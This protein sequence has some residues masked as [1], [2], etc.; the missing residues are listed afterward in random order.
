MNRDTIHDL[1]A[2]SPVLDI[3]GSGP[4]PPAEWEEDDDEHRCMECHL[5]LAVQFDTT[6]A[7]QRVI[8]LECECCHMEYFYWV[9]NGELEAQRL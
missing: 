4:L 3:G 6:I 7:G 8:V 2:E 9:E 1:L 5:P